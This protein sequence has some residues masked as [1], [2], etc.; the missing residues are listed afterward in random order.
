M[1]K[2]LFKA[3]F[4]LLLAQSFVKLVGFSYTVF[5]ARVLG[6]ENFGFYI[7]ALA[8][9]GLISSIS[10]FGFNRY[11]LREGSRDERNLPSY[12][13]NIFLLRLTISCFIFALFALWLNF[14]DTNHI[15]VS[16][17]MLV[18]MAVIPQSIALTFDA[19]LIT[20][21]KIIY[22]ALGLS[23][24]SAITAFL[25]FILVKSGFGAYGAVGALVFGQ[26]LYLFYLFILL[27]RSKIRFLSSVTYQQLK[28][29]TLGSLPYGI[30]A[31][32]GL[33][34]FR[35]DTL[36]LSY[37]KGSNDT[38]LYGVAYKFLEVLVVIPTGVSLVLF[39]FMARLH[40]SSIQ[41]VKKVYRQSLILLAFLSLPIFLVYFFIL[42]IIINLLL[43]QY[44]PSIKSIQ[45]LSFAIPFMFMQVPAVTVL[46]STEKYLKKIIFYSCFTVLFNIVLNILFIPDFGFIGASWVTVASEILSFVI[47]FF[48]IRKNIL[49]TTV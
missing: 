3:S 28:K 32:L 37:I 38:G 18:I 14:F 13:C 6:I 15:R 26:I 47:F 49:N 17:S 30:L 35:I 8:Y 25:G 2:N 11:L 24:L 22:S 46:F 29:I 9:F 23:F 16:L 41:E 45:I 40:D 42:P 12:I 48:F 10:D 19:A 1:Y 43:P 5:L 34:Y 31:V 4:Y 7:T 27:I 33:I 39:P 36:L 20:K 21:Q 44:N